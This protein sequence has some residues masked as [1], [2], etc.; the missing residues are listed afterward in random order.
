MF[1][2]KIRAALIALVTSAGFAV[3]AQAP[4]VSQAQWHNYCVKGVCT[5]H[6]NYTYGNPCSTTAAA[7]TP[8]AQKAEEEKR[9]KEEEEGKIHGEEIEKFF[10]GCDV[11]KPSPAGASKTASPIAGVTATPTRRP[12]L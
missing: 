4:A 7:L 1:T 12:V 8:E 9:K 3:A 6:A 11:A 2:T 10:W 5:E